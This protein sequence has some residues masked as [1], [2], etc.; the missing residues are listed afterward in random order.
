MST[1]E[2]FDSCQMRS[3]NRSASGRYTRKM[4]AEEDGEEWPDDVSERPICWYHNWL[5]K[6]VKA[7]I[8]GATFCFYLWL[9]WFTTRMIV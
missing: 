5:L 7:G 4:Y 1:S 9:I 2:Q 8:I 6:V 3:C